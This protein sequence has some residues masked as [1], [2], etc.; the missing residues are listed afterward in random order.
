[1]NDVGLVHF[2]DVT[3]EGDRFMYRMVRI[4]VGALV[5]VGRGRLPASA[6]A[7]ALET[8]RRQELGM[9]A[10]PDGLYLEQMVMD[11][12]GEAAWPSAEDV[13]GK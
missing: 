7:R 5:D 13:G 2:C 3:V 1:M 4:I 11:D 8:R 12:E 10:P 9:T 6:L